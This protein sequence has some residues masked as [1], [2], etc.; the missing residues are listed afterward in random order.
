[1][2]YQD[3]RVWQYGMDLTEI[4]FRAIRRIP[5]EERRDLASQMLRSSRSIASNVAEGYGRKTDREFVRF[6]RIANGSMFELETDVELIR[7]LGLLPATDTDALQAGISK[8]AGP[9]HALIQA[10]E[11]RIA[12]K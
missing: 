2:R 12:K 6:L 11:R 4:V 3:L 10:A 7:R 1:M 9:L 8:V 5:Y